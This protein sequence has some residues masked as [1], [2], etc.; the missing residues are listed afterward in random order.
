MSIEFQQIHWLLLLPLVLAAVWWIGRQMPSGFSKKWYTAMRM[1]LCAVLIV[2]M[3]NPILSMRSDTTTTIFAADRSASTAEQEADILAFLQQAQEAKGEKDVLGRISFGKRAGVEQMPDVQNHIATGFLS[4]VEE[5]GT[6]LSAALRLA[7]SILPQDSAKRVVLI[8][9]G[10]ETEGD[11]IQQAQ[12]LAAQ[13]ISVDVYPLQ[14][15]E[16]VPEVQLTALELPEV[17][18][19]NT[20]Y[21]LALRVDANTDTTAQVRLYKEQTLIADETVT[22]R[23]GENRVVFSDLTE[24]GGSVTYRAEV[25]AAQDTLSENNQMYA[26]TY[27]ADI[28]RLLIVEQDDS[29][30]EWESMLSHQA[31]VTRLSAE[32][33]PTAMEQLAVYDGVI[34]ANVS[35]EHMPDG[36]LEALEVYVRTTGGGLLVSGGENTFALGGYRATVLEEILPVDMDLKTEGQEPDLTMIMVID[37]S[38][39]MMDGSYGVTRI[40]MAKEAAIRSL[41]HFQEGDR[42]GVIAFDSQAEW[43]AQPQDVHQNIQSLTEQIGSIQAQGGTSILPALQM[44]AEA[45]EQENTKQKHILL[46]TDGQAE[47]SGYAALLQRMQAQGITL[48][49]VAVGSDADTRLLEYLADAGGGRYYF[50]DEFTD[51]P[52]IFAKETVLAG[53]EF[54]NQRSFYP[55]QQDASAILSGVDTVPM[56]DGYVSTTAKS[57]AD[58]V[59]VSDQEE[60]VLASWQYGLGR[61]VVWTADVQGQWTEQWLQTDAGVSILRNAAAW[62]MKTQAVDEILLT[63]EA[64]EE[65]TTLQLEMPFDETV[66]QVTATVVSSDRTTETVPMQMTAPGMYEGMLEMTEEGAYIANIV[67]TKRDGSQTHANTGFHIAYPAEYDMTVGQNG[68]QTLAQ[69]AEVTG[70]RILSSGAEV[71]QVDAT[72]SVME[73]SLQTV[74]LAMGVLLLLLDIAGR[75]FAFV[76]AR[77][78]SFWRKGIH[79]FSSRAKEKKAVKQTWTRQKQD[80]KAM[81]MQPQTAEKQAVKTDDFQQTEQKSTAQMLMEAKR[82]RERKP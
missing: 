79:P 37:R 29:G 57:R 68:A 12:A 47:Q 73:Q 66:T 35:A 43:T 62:M 82:R 50:T 58:V 55:Q 8:S 9:D 54:L 32:T 74:L 16:E 3:A 21:E 59:L 76:V 63:A 5:G 71:F 64:G 15:A 44:A 34:L 60:P 11:G 45:M 31:A 41:A 14:S 75:R 10:K 40:D 56:L 81:S 2:A 67:M 6:S 22:I 24:R 69:I 19:P 1:L 26:Y 27:I 51:L 80:E 18:R 48:S 61:T 36:F 23:S 39:S 33:A 77:I 4:V 78:E 13:G 70:G 20:R 7:A 52:E 42:V 25:T 17:I 30:R 72:Q 38:G 65:S 49:A 53:K 46:L 28:P